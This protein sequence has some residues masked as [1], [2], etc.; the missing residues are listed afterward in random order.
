M[1]CCSVL[2]WGLSPL[3]CCEYRQ[4]DFNAVTMINS[5]WAKTNLTHNTVAHAMYGRVARIVIVQINSLSH[6]PT[7]PM[8]SQVP[9]STDMKAIWRISTSKQYFG[10]TLAPTPTIY[11][12]ANDRPT[13]TSDPRPGNLWIQCPYCFCCCC[14]VCVESPVTQAF[15]SSPPSDGD[16]VVNVRTEV[17]PVANGEC[18][19]DADVVGVHGVHG[20]QDLAA[21]VDLDDHRMRDF[22]DDVHQSEAANLKTK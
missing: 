3:I 9:H 19:A 13:S 7:S 18:A 22:C 1:K 2:F 11:N 16:R 15:T 17:E 8:K 5:H 10:R 4:R 14:F 6:L 21:S 20:A 12:K